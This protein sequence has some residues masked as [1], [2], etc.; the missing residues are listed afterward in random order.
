[1]PPQNR[2]LLTSNHWGTYSVEVVDGRV[3]ALRGF[4]EDPD[5]S[6]I[7]HGKFVAMKNSELKWI[8][9]PPMPASGT[10]CLR[11]ACLRQNNRRN[12]KW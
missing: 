7:G 9:N 8:S 10:K 2:G 4:E 12:P 5:P 1:M 6:P 11:K 3:T